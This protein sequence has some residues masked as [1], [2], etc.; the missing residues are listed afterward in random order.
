MNSIV[1][2][3][4]IHLLTIFTKYLKPEI[5]LDCKTNNLVIEQCQAQ[6]ILTGSVSRVCSVNSENIKKIYYPADTVL[7]VTFI[8]VENQS[9]VPHNNPNQYVVHPDGEVED[10]GPQ[11][12]G[13]DG[14]HGQDGQGGQDDEH[15]VDCHQID[16]GGSGEV[17]WDD[18]HLHLH[19]QAQHKGAEQDQDGRGGRVDGDNHQGRQEKR[20]GHADTVRGNYDGLRKL[21]A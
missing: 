9:H 15:G 16:S 20:R 6:E 3:S 19:D 13:G 5:S 12:G 2:S 4:I 7:V 17:Q 11:R 18:R 21:F 10:Q 14:G 8:S 1:N